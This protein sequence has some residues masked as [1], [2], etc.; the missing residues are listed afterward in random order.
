M[1]PEFQSSLLHTDYQQFMPPLF[2]EH[3][4][5]WK[6]ELDVLVRQI[7]E[8]RGV[9][10]NEPLDRKTLPGVLALRLLGFHTVSS[11]EG[12]TDPN[13]TLARLTSPQIEVNILPPWPHY[14]DEGKFILA[15][16]DRYHLPKEKILPQGERVHDDWPTLGDFYFPFHEE[17]WAWSQFQPETAEYRQAR[18]HAHKEWT[19]LGTLLD[20]FYNGGSRNAET[21]IRLR[22]FHEFWYI[23][24]FEQE[25]RLDLLSARQ[26]E[27]LNFGEFLLARHLTN[28]G[29]VLVSD[30]I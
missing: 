30:S 12:H 11:C 15:F 6:P 25:H 4:T 14:V 16:C 19:R 9:F 10:M 20:S 23:L 8:G 27:M 13:R 26:R 21:T 29:K 5:A 7:T 22:P 1:T 28:E 3:K 24:D 17:L 2:R 18:L